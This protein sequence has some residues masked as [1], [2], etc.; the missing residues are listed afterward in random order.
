MYSAIIYCSKTLRQSNTE[1]KASHFKLKFLRSK[2]IS[3]LT[4]KTLSL[5]LLM[6]QCTTD[7]T[8]RKKNNVPLFSALYSLT[9]YFSRII[10]YYCKPRF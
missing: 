3:K 5:H 7:S 1:N 8:T 2:Q 9:P 4:N 10:N 6:K